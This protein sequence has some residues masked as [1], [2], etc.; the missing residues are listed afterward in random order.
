MASNTQISSYHNRV[1][2]I[3]NRNVLTEPMTPPQ[4]VQSS[5]VPAPPTV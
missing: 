1:D 2:V 3:P 4:V 5:Y